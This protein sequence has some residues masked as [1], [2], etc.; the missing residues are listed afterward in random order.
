MRQHL[1]KLNDRSARLQLSKGIAMDGLVRLD[2][3]LYPNHDMRSGKIPDPRID[4][5]LQSLISRASPKHIIE[6]FLRVGLS[7][8]AMQLACAKCSHT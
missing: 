3:L 7:H 2:L 1:F 6:D 8:A 4:I 5:C